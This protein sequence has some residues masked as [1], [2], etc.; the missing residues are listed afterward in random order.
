MNKVYR[1]KPLAPDEYLGHVRADGKV[2]ESRLGADKYIGRVELESG[3]IFEARLGPDKHIGHVDVESGKV[4]LEHF[5]PDEYLGRVRKDGKLYHHKFLASD[6]YMGKVTDMLSLAHG[7]AAF[8]LLVRPAFDEQAERVEE[9]SE[10]DLN[11]AEAGHATS[12][13]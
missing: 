2:Y 5:G 8:L 10:Q 4:Y 12:P 13:A 7:G 1:Q 3:K 6:E 9:E 11:D